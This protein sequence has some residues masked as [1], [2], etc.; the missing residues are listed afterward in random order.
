MVKE[1][2]SKLIFALVCAGIGWSAA[3]SVC[4]RETVTSLP[5][6]GFS[7]PDPIPDGDARRYPYFRFDGS[8]RQSRLRQWKT[9]VLEN[10]RIRV[11][12]IPGIGGKIWGATDKVT[13]R[14]FIY[15]NNVVKFR[16]IAT[17]GPWTS[18][19]IEFNFGLIGHS[20]STS[21]PVDWCVRTNSD[22]SVSYFCSNR[23]LI[24]DST[25]QVEVNLREG[26]DFFT[27]RTLWANTS[28]EIA[29]YYQWMNAAFSTRGDP[30]LAFPGDF[31]IGHEGD[32]HPWP[33]KDGRAVN[34]VNNN[35]F[36]GNKSYHV[37]GGDA[38]V[39][40]VWWNDW[41]LG[42]YHWNAF[43]EKYGRKAWIWA[44]SREGA[45][46]E[47][48]LTDNDGQYMELQSG[49]AFNQPRRSTFRTPFKHPIFAP[50]TVDAFEERWGVA[51]IR[52]DFDA[53][54]ATTTDVRRAEIAPADFNW[55]TAYGRFV[56]GEQALR[57]RDDV[58]ADEYL[59]KS[60]AT[61]PCFV[62][63]LNALAELD[64]R[65][66]KMDEALALAE[67]A[68]AVNAYDPAANYR[69][70]RIAAVKGDGMKAL[71]RLGLA[72]YSPEFRTAA[73]CEMAKI[74]LRLGDVAEA[75]RL[76]KKASESCA[77]SIEAFVLRTLALRI[78]GKSE[79]AREE[80]AHGLAVW[81]LAHQLRC[82]A[83]FDGQI[84]KAEF[85][86]GIRGEFPHETLLG[87]GFWY[88][89]CGRVAEAREL[90]ALCGSFLGELACA[91][92]DGDVG[93]LGRIAKGSVRF[94]HPFREESVADLDWAIEHS[95]SWKFRYLRAV[96][97]S[98]RGDAEMAGN[99][100]N[101]VT[102]ADDAVFYLYRARTCGEHERR[103]ADLD[104]AAQLE[105]SWRV[106]RA[107]MSLCAA[108]GDW[109]TAARVGK[110]YL[111]R[112]PHCNPIE[113]LY[114]KALVA[115][116][117]YRTCL[118]FLKG[119]DILPSEF[120]D[121]A[122]DS[123][124]ACQA[125][126]GLELT[127]PENLGCGRPYTRTNDFDTAAAWVTGVRFGRGANCDRKTPSPKFAVG[128]RL[129]D[130]REKDYV[131][132]VV[133]FKDRHYLQRKFS[134][135]ELVELEGA[136]SLGFRFVGLTEEDEGVSFSDGRLFRERLDPIATE[137]SPKR[138]L[139]LQKGQDVGNNVGDG[140]LPFPTG[141]RTVQPQAASAKLPCTCVP[142]FA[143]GAVRLEE[144][145]F[146]ELKERR[147]G[148]VLTVEAYAPA[149]RVTEVNLGR[150]VEAAVERQIRVPYL[151]DFG[152][153]DQLAG[154]FFRFAFFDWYRSNAS[155]IRVNSDGTVSAVYRPKTDGSYNP[156]CERIVITLSDD[157]ADV[158]PEIPNPPSPYK[159][160]V[161]ERLWRSHAASDRSRDKAFWRRMHA[162]G[163]R[164]LCVM[165]H[166]TMWR[167]GGEAFTM[168]DC[169]ATGKGG[170]EAQRD[171]TR[172]MID[173][174]GYVYGPYNN[175]TDFQP[176]N[177][178]W[179]DVDR[180]VRASDG[181]LVSAWLRSYAPKASAILPICEAV[182]PKVQ[183]KF[184]FR[185]AYCDVHTAVR[186]WARTDYDARIPGA[187]TFAQVYYAWGEL[188]LR[189]RELWNG[190]VWSE[191]GCHF[192]FAGLTDGNYAQDRGY[193]FLNAPWIVD[194]DLL[195]I[196]PL[197]CDFGM[198]SLSM[199][200]P[201]KNPDDASFYL[202]GMPEGRERLVDAFIAATLAFGHNGLL[203]AD[204]CW[205]PAKMFGPA[206]C[207]A[208]EETFED[209]L[210]IAK[211]SYFMVQAIA[212]RY[213]Q[214]TVNDIRY[215]D[216][217][218]Q[219]HSTAAAL[220]NGAVAR[221]Q[222]Y[223]RYTG[224]VHVVVN[225]NAVERLRAKVG[226]VGIDLPPYGYRCWTEDG[227]VLVVS[228]DNGG[229]GRRRDFAKCET[230]EY[231]STRDL[232][233]EQS[234]TITPKQAKQERKEWQ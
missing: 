158:L 115:L 54:C 88:L 179:W 185:G 133:D 122:T 184:G 63:S 20:M 137:K 32:A 219:P 204:W 48:L 77:T 107:K 4:V 231:S 161:G 139:K 154:G 99:L 171:Y 106:G 39:F 31:E 60:L 57:E 180:V 36:G 116:K 83:Y 24:V 34:F 189:Q 176:N 29:P 65:R 16:N 78:C 21:T 113:I 119:V 221:R 70:G 67:K 175:Y 183:R 2:S 28:N 193:D 198:G 38:R 23:E 146:L 192:L 76:S 64:F 145:P 163:I 200:S 101:G 90:F 62:P 43:G 173:E 141:E 30:E 233:S 82:E 114:A 11:V 33:E 79:K 151:T 27:T 84:D 42:A 58:V 41:G 44:L 132:G 40:G 196:H 229:T 117:D 51:R 127:W 93:A 95:H 174:L 37:V 85:R 172:I 191:G 111:A 212:A 105:D 187:G 153:V 150:A 7:D 3:A 160:L 13:G 61:E 140:T 144:R 190:P 124:H 81:P 211:R 223:V 1:I 167:D 222:I 178:T 213:S 169:A 214:E 234:A 220:I 170:D 103:L 230:Y 75:L 15:C 104:L 128:F 120:G 207:G 201:P 168:T 92:L 188:L 159:R 205:K 69:A 209:G 181:S 18:G 217:D 97:A 35:D 10:D 136:V 125:A 66:G 182:V 19:G 155:L 208:S 45:I 215:F 26:D 142:I 197:E 121:N 149:G 186:P 74:E 72:A 17:R 87:L 206:Y 118:E 112:Y 130:G 56:R 94:V 14:D 194:F 68:L 102:D 86:E 152:K 6:F 49:R 96:V 224:G 195:K 131:L 50:G 218:G 156:V 71:E 129:R 80:I 166:E 47:D 226:D 216:V 164:Q 12:A 46:W 73:L 227:K 59:R 22:S 55:D 110:D 143:G 157:F 138:N 89:S 98:V 177:A 52:A 225:G 108:V 8:V 147:E 202:P 135:N 9:V 199:F 228:D 165:D 109:R 5:T 123:W 162:N 100:L 25:W 210:E 126:L 53:V 203:L 91:H 232:N 134:T 148:R